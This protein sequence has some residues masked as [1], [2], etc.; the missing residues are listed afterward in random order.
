[1]PAMGTNIQL[2]VLAG[3]GLIVGYVIA[4]VAEHLI[5]SPPFFLR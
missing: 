5:H 1:M 2:H 3:L 4:I